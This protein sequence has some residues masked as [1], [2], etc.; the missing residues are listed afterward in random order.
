M[1]N[2]NRRK[3]RY[4]Q[5]SQAPAPLE[6]K[7]PNS[8]PPS[9]LP[10]DIP[11]E[12]NLFKLFWSL[13]PRA[14]Q[15][16]FWPVVAILSLIGI[17]DKWFPPPRLDVTDHLS[18]PRVPI[19]GP[20]FLRNVGSSTAYNIEVSYNPYTV[21]AKNT[22]SLANIDGTLNPRIPKLGEGQSQRIDVWKPWGINLGSNI[23]GAQ[24]DIYVVYNP[25]RFIP[26]YKSQAVFKFDARP[27]SDGT[28]CWDPSSLRP[29][30]L[31]NFLELRAEMLSKMQ[32][33]P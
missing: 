13:L 5:L 14:V 28:M 21:Y 24:M 25:Y 8:P 31:E 4:L 22:R 33:V 1:S 23:I 2:R 19:Q 26:L 12:G 9:S 15:R 32:S 17:W 3:R 18:D 6:Q 30:L 11:D 7:T 20:F 27:L 29:P 16:I 10:I